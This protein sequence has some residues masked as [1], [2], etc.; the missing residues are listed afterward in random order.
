[1]GSQ[2]ELPTI[3]SADQATFWAL[4]LS[5]RLNV[6][7]K[8]TSV[9][10]LIHG[11]PD[12][13]TVLK[14]NITSI[15]GTCLVEKRWLTHLKALKSWNVSRAYSRCFLPLFRIQ[16]STKSVRKTCCQEGRRSWAWGWGRE[17]SRWWC[18]RAEMRKSKLAKWERA[19]SYQGPTGPFAILRGSFTTCL[20]TLLLSWVWGSEVAEARANRVI[21]DWLRC[22]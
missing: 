15:H 19:K 4:T 12:R 18:T 10:S 5:Q 22:A 11:A 20:G 1:M 9:R 21:V 6:V 17:G 13:I 2:V 8:K 3:I 16:P 14:I 7:R